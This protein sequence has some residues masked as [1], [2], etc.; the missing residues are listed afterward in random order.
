MS[1]MKKRTSHYVMKPASY[2]I[3]CDKCGGYN[4]EWSEFDKMIWCYDCKIDTKGTPGIF[5]GPVP[6]EACA[7]MGISFDRWDMVKKRVLTWDK[8]KHKYVPRTTVK[9]SNASSMASGNWYRLAGDHDETQT[10][11]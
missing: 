2:Q 10:P 4:I 8:Y 3:A 1:K 6:V 7:V 9:P 11:E 5:D